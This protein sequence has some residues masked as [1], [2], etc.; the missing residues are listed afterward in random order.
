[1]GIFLITALISGGLVLL[2]GPGL[3]VWRPALSAPKKIPTWL[4]MPADYYRDAF[5]IA[6][7]GGGILIGL[8]RL[9]GMLDVWVAD[10]PSRVGRQVFGE[11]FDAL[12]PAAGIV[13]GALVRGL[14]FN[15]N[16]LPWRLRF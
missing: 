8:R 7:G 3:V 1:V 12:Y 11:S 9:L 15:G 2:F 16:F 4:G 6:V 14:P 10:P 5:W 13:G